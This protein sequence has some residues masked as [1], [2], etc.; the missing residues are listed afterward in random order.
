[1]HEYGH[2]ECHNEAEH[3]HCSHDCAHCGGDPKQE[4]KALMDYMVKHNRTHCAELEVVAKQLEKQGNT[5]GYTQVMKA[6]ADFE[7]GNL[8]IAAVLA[9]ME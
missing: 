1:M 7:Q 3:R 9:A 8:R 2:E 4:L 6:V 5:M